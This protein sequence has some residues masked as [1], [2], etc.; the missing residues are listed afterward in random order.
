[1][2]AELVYSNVI[3]SVLG[4]TSQRRVFP[5]NRLHWHYT[6]Y[7]PSTKDHR[8]KTALCN[9]TNYR[10]VLVLY[11]LYD[12]RPENGPGPILTTPDSA[13]GNFSQ[14]VKQA[15]SQPV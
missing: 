11:N 10:Q 8:K 4:L 12:F 1:M 14:C 15:I 13:R 6:T 2:T 5:D 3:V 9:K 7:T